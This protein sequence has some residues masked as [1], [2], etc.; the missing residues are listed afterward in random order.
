MAH[1]P[2]VPER[3][4]RIT[5]KRKE[6]LDAMLVGP[7]APIYG[8]GHVMAALVRYGLA[9]KWESGRL[10]IW[11]LKD[12]TSERIRAALERGDH[13]IVEGESEVAGD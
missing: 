7:I 12:G 9:E 10:R 11:R 8:Y 4:M 2:I 3:D 5:Q 6:L 1:S 13:E